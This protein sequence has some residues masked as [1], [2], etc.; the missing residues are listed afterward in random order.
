MFTDIDTLND[1]HWYEKV[2][3]N[4]AEAA[5]DERVIAVQAWAKENYTRGA[6]VIV[7]AC[8]TD[9]ILGLIVDFGGE[10]ATV[11]EAVK[12]AA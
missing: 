5:K 1:P 6:D 4:R 12:I 11:E 7:E 8:E 9:E 10:S 2:K 3:A